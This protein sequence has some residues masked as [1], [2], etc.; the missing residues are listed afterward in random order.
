M[1]KEH[2][3]LL[4]ELHRDVV[5]AGLGNVSCDLAGVFVSS[6]LIVRVSVSGQHFALMDKPDTSV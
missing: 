3:N 4:S 1:R 5:L 6:R 2:L